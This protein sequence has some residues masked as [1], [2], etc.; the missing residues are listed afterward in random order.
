MVYI[1]VCVCSFFFEGRWKSSKDADKPVL[2]SVWDSYPLKPPPCS[3]GQHVPLQD[4]CDTT[5]L[6]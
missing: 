1:C 3:I 4:I 5:C 2:I 6:V